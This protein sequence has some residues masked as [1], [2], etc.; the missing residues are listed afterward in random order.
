[1]NKLHLVLYLAFIAFAAQLGAQSV[2]NPNNTIVRFAISTGGTNVGNMDIE[3]FDE[4]KPQ[5]VKNFL[6]YIYSGA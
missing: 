3:L 6:L 4:E 2:V 5:T 1:M